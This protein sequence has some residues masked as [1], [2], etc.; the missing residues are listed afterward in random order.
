MGLWSITV[1]ICTHNLAPECDGYRGK[2]L[3]TVVIVFCSKLLEWIQHWLFCTLKLPVKL[4]KETM[5]LTFCFQFRWKFHCHSKLAIFYTTDARLYFQ[6]I[7]GLFDE[8]I[9]L[10]L[11]Y[12]VNHLFSQGANECIYSKLNYDIAHESTG[13]S[14]EYTNGFSFTI[15]FNGWSKVC[16]FIHFIYNLH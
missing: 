2:V 11:F 3:H 15:S 8:W 7:W 1:Y 4:W 14:D 9:W 13:V 16:L 5:G 12:L 10:P 6:Q